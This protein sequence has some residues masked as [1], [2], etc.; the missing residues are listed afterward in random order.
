[1]STLKTNVHLYICSYCMMPSDC[2][3]ML[4][5]FSFLLGGEGVK[6]DAWRSYRDHIIVHLKHRYDEEP[7]VLFH[8]YLLGMLICWVCMR[9]PALGNLTAHTGILTPG[10]I[11]FCPE[12]YCYLVTKSSELQI[13]VLAKKRPGECHGHSGPPLVTSAN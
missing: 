13:V 12:K 9:C 8:K 7:Q 2:L 4:C 1:M 6:V 3:R 11:F 10:Q 5:L